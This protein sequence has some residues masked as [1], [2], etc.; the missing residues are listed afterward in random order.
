MIR[1]FTRFILGLPKRYTIGGVVAV[2][3]I[4]FVGA[5]FIERPSVAVVTLSGI[6]HVRV[7]SVGGLSSQTGPLPVTGKVTSLSHATI[8]AVTSGEIVSLSHAIG[9]QVSAGEV[10]AQLENSSQQAAV[11]QA[12]GAYDGAQA[13]LAK[14]SGTTAQNSNITSVQAGTSAQNT[15]LSAQTALQSAYASLDDAVHAKADLLFN[16]PHAQNPTLLSFTIP[17]SQLVINVQNERAGLD[18]VLNSARPLAASSGDVD[19]NIA[20]MN[21]YAQ[22]IAVFLNDLNL[23]INEAVPNQYYATSAI[24]AD[25]A[26]TAAARTE[27]VAAIGNITGAK[28][29]YD[30]ALAGSLSAANSASSGSQSDISAAQANVKQAQGALN[31]AQANLEKTIV[32]SPISGTIVSLPVSKGDYVTAF[33]E[34]ADV[35]NPGALFVDTYVTPSDAQTLAV[36]NKATIDTNTSGVI[37]FI[38]PALDP[39]TGK[40]EVKIG[41]TGSVG[42]L[43]DGETMT[44]SLDRTH[45]GTTN[46]NAS[47]GGPPGGIVI[48]IESAKITPSGPVVFTVTAS[49]TLAAH[50]IV[51]GAILGD[52]V[53]VT[54]GLT[55]DMD[56]VTDARGLSDGQSVI[57]DAQ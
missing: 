44:V 13:A 24:S 35:S 54:S 1:H 19:M 21:A 3:V 26:A 52:Q 43:T 17:D 38:A 45:E 20:T 48:P 9:D 2:V 29:T 5:H 7:S 23:A 56:I 32:R 47:Q 31:A 39:L 30:A 42:A 12:Q 6:S 41:V 11:L 46:A 16:N 50:P 15:K 22:T 8:L 18:Q 36:G 57:I 33:S 4:G 25:Q 55:F 27:V 37:T 49:S 40:I 53:T 14:A 10:I 34:V 28:S 51:F